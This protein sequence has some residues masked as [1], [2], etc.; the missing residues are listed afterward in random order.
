MD[1]VHDH[2]GWQGFRAQVRERYIAG[3]LT[4]DELAHDVAIAA[5]LEE[6]VL[7]P[8]T[9]IPEYLR[10]RNGYPLTVR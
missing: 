4:I 3:E 8:G 10:D 7:P 9:E 6:G 1:G 5:Q 2:D